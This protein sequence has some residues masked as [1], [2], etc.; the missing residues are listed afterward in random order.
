MIAQGWPPN[1]TKIACA[2]TPDNAW[3]ICPMNAD[4]SGQTRLTTYFA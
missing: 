3:D 2:S 1:S 4:G